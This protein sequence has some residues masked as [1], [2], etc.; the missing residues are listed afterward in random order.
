MVVQ[1]TQFDPDT[2]EPIATPA[3][4]ALPATTAA[5]DNSAAIAALA[6][7]LG[8]DTPQTRALAQGLFSR[9]ISNL[10]DIAFKEGKPGYWSTQ[11]DSQ[12]GGSQTNVWVDDP[13]R[14]NY[15]FYNKLTNAPI[16]PMRIGAYDIPDKGTY[17]FNLTPNGFENWF[18]PRATGYAPAIASFLSMTP[19]APIAG[20]YNAYK[21]IDK[22]DVIGGLANLAAV[23]GM[24][25]LSNELKVV[26]AIKQGNVG[27]A[28]TSLGQMVLPGA[29]GETKI[30]DFTLSDIAKG[31]S[32]A[33]NISSG[34]Y[35]A[36]LQAAG[37][38]AGSK[39]TVMAAKGAS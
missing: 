23:G 18:N 9:G 2:G 19:L 1:N 34:N 32:I 12:S 29:L 31:A 38:L 5:P 14:I 30:G 10:S 35:T 25:G 8:G 6:T 24:S 20:V 33:S 39:D 17:F 7:Q 15:D 27:D 28:L 3:A 21:A 4:S 16:D 26:N 11:D 37:E 36:A 22:G 13:T